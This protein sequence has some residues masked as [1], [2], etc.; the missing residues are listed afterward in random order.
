MAALISLPP[1]THFGKGIS[2][3]ADPNSSPAVMGGNCITNL[4]NMNFTTEQLPN[5]SHK[6]C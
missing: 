2:T 5:A 1:A 4:S 3:E 6:L